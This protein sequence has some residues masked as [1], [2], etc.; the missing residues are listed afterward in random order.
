MLGRSSENS[1]TPNKKSR[2]SVITMDTLMNMCHEMAK[3][4]NK[5]FFEALNSLHLMANISEHRSEYLND[6][7]LTAKE[8]ENYELAQMIAKFVR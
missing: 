5:P 8:H 4:G 2:N 1:G 3:E 6:L 7:I